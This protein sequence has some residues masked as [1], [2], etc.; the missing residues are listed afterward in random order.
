MKQPICSIQSEDLIN[1]NNVKMHK[2]IHI[3]IE[4][5]HMAG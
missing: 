4:I 5:K 2:E 3:T 1:I